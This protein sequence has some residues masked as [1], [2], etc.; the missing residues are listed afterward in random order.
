MNIGESMKKEVKKVDY[1]NTSLLKTLK[2]RKIN[3]ARLATV[4]GVA[5][6]TLFVTTTI[7]S[8]IVNNIVK[9]N[10]QSPIIEKYKYIEL[11]DGTYDINLHDN[12]NY[13]VINHNL[14]PGTK[15]DENTFVT[16][17]MTAGITDP[18][19]ILEYA[20]N[21]AAVAWYLQTGNVIGLPSEL[22]FSWGDLSEKD[23]AIAD[24]NKL[25]ADV[26]NGKVIDPEIKKVI[27]ETFSAISNNLDGVATKLEVIHQPDGK[28]NYQIV[29]TT[30][31]KL[32]EQ[33]K[34]K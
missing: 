25:L 3:V 31:E 22:E 27:G 8:N 28:V 10:E 9:E 12:Q 23:I 21:K 24:Y 16:S 11:E 5:Y 13:T 14:K 29:I 4:A 17:L 19:K 15:L 7:G 2:R 34:Q 6:L 18:L 32:Q 30:L 33:N 20:E 1:I 26:R